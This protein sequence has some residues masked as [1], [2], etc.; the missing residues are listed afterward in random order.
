MI[1]LGVFIESVIFGVIKKFLKLLLLILNC[2]F[3]VIRIDFY[4][5][6]VVIGYYG[7]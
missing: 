2:F 4:F 7:F 3:M 5:L 6:V 1:E